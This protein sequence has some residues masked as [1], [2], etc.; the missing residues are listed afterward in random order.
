MKTPFLTLTMLSSISI[1][2]QPVLAASESSAKP[3]VSAELNSTVASL[4]LQ[5]RKNPS[6]LALR[7]QLVEALLRKGLSVKAAEQMQGLLKAGLRSTE[8]FCLLAD[9][10]RYAGKL[11]SAVLNYQEALNL[12]PD[13]VHAKSGLALCY[14]LAGNAGVG[15]KVCKE[16]MKNAQDTKSRNELS[17]TLKAIKDAKSVGAGSGAASSAAL[18]SSTY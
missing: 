11:S 15:E 6:D 7:R 14:M 16:A 8:D 17:M 12:A 13:N 3:L 5:I 9:C 4:S 1:L 2:M 10:Y 18:T